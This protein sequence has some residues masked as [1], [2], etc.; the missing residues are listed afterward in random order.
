MTELVNS[1]KE[2]AEEITIDN[3]KEF[4][5]ITTLVLTFVFCVVAVSPIA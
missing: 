2:K 5:E 4:V 1:I 3:F